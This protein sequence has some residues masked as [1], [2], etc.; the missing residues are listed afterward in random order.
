M[1]TADTKKENTQKKDADITK[2]EII[3]RI[4]DVYKRCVQAEPILVYDK[5]L[6]S[7]VNS[8]EWKFDASNALKAL[9]M[10]GDI[11]GIFKSSEEINDSFSTSYEEF[12]K[13]G[14]VLFDF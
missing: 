10:L 8:G 11:S 5:E 14:S 1:K 12:L 3:R 2:E 4:D 7:Y 13:S 9:K 6:K